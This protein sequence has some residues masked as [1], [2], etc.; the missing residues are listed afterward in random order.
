MSD[1]SALRGYLDS[2]REMEP[3]LEA[4]LP[5]RRRALRRAQ[6][7]AVF[8]V[9]DANDRLIARFRP[10]TPAV[11]STGQWPW[12]ADVEAATPAIR[13]ELL[14]YLQRSTMPSVAAI[15]GL[16]DA[17]AESNRALGV[18]G[19]WRAVNMFTNGR[20]IEETARHFPTTTALF[21]DVHPKAN[22][23]F[24]AL[25][26]HSHIE[27]HVG[28]NRGALRF[29]LPV[30]VPGDHGDC[31]IR[32]GDQMIRWREGE[33]VV[34]D[35]KTNHE[36]WNDTSELRVLLMVEIAMPLPKPLSWVNRVAQISYRWHPSYRGMPER[37]ADLA[38][39]SA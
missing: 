13:D 32:V 29:Q 33:A 18:V 38:R 28:P 31:R 23:G 35:L 8:A 24:S 30:I 10:G 26:P 2:A 4:S 12:I 3:V 17:D 9:L 14:A 7:A 19:N 25:E 21:H 16:D 36:A 15:S 37:I 27:P 34:F 20:W 1:R 6:S 22:L 39:Q 5:R 11:W